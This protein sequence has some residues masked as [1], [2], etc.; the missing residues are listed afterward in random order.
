MRVS[1]RGSTAINTILFTAIKHAIQKSQKRTERT[2]LSRLI[3][4]TPYF[5]AAMLTITGKCISP[6]RNP[7][8]RGTSSPVIC[9]NTRN[10]WVPSDVRIRAASEAEGSRGR[11]VTNALPACGNPYP[12]GRKTAEKP[13]CLAG[14]TCGCSNG[15][16]LCSNTCVDLASN[17]ANCGVCGHACTTGPCVGGSCS[18]CQTASCN[19]PA[20]CAGA[21]Y[22]CIN[23][24]C[25][26]AVQ[27]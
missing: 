22:A 2:L 4:T 11:I 18:T 24:C 25:A 10:G 26:D 7:T 1:T 8:K 12:F 13:N 17:N 6:T 16:A 23:G 20:D 3:A 27:Q 21:Y 5:I 19:T 14:G 9:R 15:L